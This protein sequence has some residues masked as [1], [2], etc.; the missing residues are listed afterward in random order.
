MNA[1]IQEVNICRSLGKD[2]DHQTE[3]FKLK[4][5]VKEHISKNPKIIEC[6]AKHPE[7]KPANSIACD[8]AH[9]HHDNIMESIDYLVKAFLKEFHDVGR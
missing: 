2:D 3:I 9:Q 4:D 1:I 5:L 7:C 6:Y 8:L